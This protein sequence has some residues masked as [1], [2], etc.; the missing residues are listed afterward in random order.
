MKD[1]CKNVF[2]WCEIWRKSVK[3]YIRPQNSSP[4]LCVWYL[5]KSQLYTTLVFMK[6]QTV[7]IGRRNVILQAR[8]QYRGSQKIESEIKPKGKP[9]ANSS[10]LLYKHVDK[11]LTAVFYWPI[12]WVAIWPANEAWRTFCGFTTR[13]LSCINCFLHHLKL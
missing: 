6:R 11:S 2:Q 12:H 8:N 13:S 7:I 9:P 4:L 1:E 10:C 3:V 5:R